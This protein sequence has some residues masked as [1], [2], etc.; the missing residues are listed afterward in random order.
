MKGLQEPWPLLDRLDQ[1]DERLSARPAIRP[2]GCAFMCSVE[3]GRYLAD[4]AQD[5]SSDLYIERWTPLQIIALYDTACEKGYV[6]ARDAY[7]ERWEDVINLAAGREAVDYQGHAPADQAYTEDTIVVSCWER[8]DMNV[9]VHFTVSIP[10]GGIQYDSL[11]SAEPGLSN[12][13]KY[14][15]VVSTRV[16]KVL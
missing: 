14:G 4:P 2:Y 8:Q 3:I 10:Q 1:R 9:G 15:I 16:F 12:S 13:R 7:I 5:P 6:R 11:G